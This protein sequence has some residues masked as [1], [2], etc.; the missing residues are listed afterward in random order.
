LRQTVVQRLTGASGPPRE[1]VALSN[2]RHIGLMQRA[3]AHLARARSAAGC[4]TPEEFLLIDLQAARAC[5][6]EV[7]GVRTPD[8]VLE[9]IF[10]RFCIGK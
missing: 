6:D 3:R 8:D 4:Q 2:S 9:Q 10:A 5:F 1:S 7:V